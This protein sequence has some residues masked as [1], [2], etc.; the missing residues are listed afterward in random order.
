MPE[1][2]I[3]HLTWKPTVSTF[4]YCRRDKIAL[5]TFLFT[6]VLLTAEQYAQRT[7]GFPLEQ[8]LSERPTVSR[9]VILPLLFDLLP[10]LRFITDCT[11][12]ALCFHVHVNSCKLVIRPVTESTDSA[13]STITAAPQQEQKQGRPEKRHVFENIDRSCESTVPG[14]CN[15]GVLPFLHYNPFSAS[16]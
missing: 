7:V 6:T 10:Q 12:T 16:T 5:K 2:N 14:W 3:R 1:K 15:I 13:S 4:Y 9:Y 11:N 8:W